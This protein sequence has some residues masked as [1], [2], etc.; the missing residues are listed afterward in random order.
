MYGVQLDFDLPMFLIGAAFLLLE[1]RGVTALSLLFGSTWIVNAFVFIG[2]LIMLTGTAMALA[3][4]LIVRKYPMMSTT[5]LFVAL[6]LS[7]VAL[8]QFDIALLNALPFAARGI[9]LEAETRHAGGFIHA[10]PVR[11]QT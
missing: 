10:I 4:T 5:P 8:W 6:G 2:I 1:T 7:T 9:Y 11:R 3:A